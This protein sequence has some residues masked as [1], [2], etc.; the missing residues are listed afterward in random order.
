MNIAANIDSLAVDAMT[1]PPADNDHQRTV[2]IKH[3]I[4]DA[5]NAARALFPFLQY[6]DALGASIMIAAITGMIAS[7]TL[8]YAG[9]LS[10]WIS[11]PLSAFFASLIHEIEH[12]LIHTLYFR[13]NK[14]IHNTL[15][16]LCWL[17][18]PLTINPWIRRRLHLNH[19]KHSGT[20][21]DIEERAITNGERWNGWRLLMMFDGMASILVRA[22]RGPAQQ[23][24][25]VLKRGLLA[26]LPLGLAA[27][28]C[29]YVFV[30]AHALQWF[31]QLLNLPQPPQTAQVFLHLIDII[32]VTLLAPNLLRSFSINLISS[33]MHYY[34]DIEPGN[35]VQQTQFLM[36]WW[37]LPFQAFCFNFGGTHA[38]HHFV[39]GQPFYLRQIIAGKVRPLMRAEGVRHNDTASLTRANRWSI[40]STTADAGAAPAT[41]VRVNNAPAANGAIAIAS[42]GPSATN[43]TNAAVNLI[44]KPAANEDNFKTLRCIVCFAEYSEAFGWPDDGIPAGT[45]WDAVPD[46][47]ICPECGARKADFVMVET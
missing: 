6:Q 16:A 47:W 8:W 37:L 44:S 13:H 40:P 5:G 2:A 12:D 22:F 42:A 28:L 18:R 32:T 4:V 31:A 24:S 46:D 29:W 27:W 14:L 10:P 1:A 15:M 34:G 17:A 3:V 23:R 38:I 9:L 20:A 30:I 35:V 45:R 19:H 39:V 43:A 25:F 36:P 26:Y 33:N 7:G 41:S 21:T 11:I